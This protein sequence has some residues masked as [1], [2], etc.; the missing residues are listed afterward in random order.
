VIAYA[1]PKKSFITSD[2]PILTTMPGGH[3]P[4]LGVGLSTPGSEKVAPLSS[5]VAL[6]MW[7]V[8][9]APTV[10]YGIID[11]DRLRG[12][13][14]T[15]TRASERF[16]VGRSKVLLESILR[17]TRVAGTAPPRRVARGPESET[18]RDAP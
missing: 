18:K 10:G 11:G 2:A 14:E 3:N 15:L 5:R 9:A 7:D 4:L 16:A 8:R 13:N 6:L 1:P 12:L 17:R